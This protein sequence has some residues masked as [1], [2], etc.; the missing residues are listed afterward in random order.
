MVGSVFN[1][2]LYQYLIGAL[3]RSGLTISAVFREAVIYT[4]KNHFSPNQE[5][6][7]GVGIVDLLQQF[8]HIGH[9]VDHSTTLS[10]HLR[11][12]R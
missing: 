3:P 4:T 6:A 10:G 1:T 5:N 8:G 7:S 12:A 11:S 9:F 2:V